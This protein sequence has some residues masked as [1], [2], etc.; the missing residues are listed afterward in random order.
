MNQRK[1]CFIDRDGTIIQEPADEQVDSIDKLDLL[2][3]V[4]PALIQLQLAGFVLVMV[5]NQDGLGSDSFPSEQFWPV[6]Q[7]LERLLLSQGIVFDSVRI[8]PHM[9]SDKCTCRKPNVGL[10]LDYLTSQQIDRQNSY[11]IGDRASDSQ[12]ADNMGINSILIDGK[13]DWQ[14]IFERIVNKPRVACVKRKTNETNITGSLNLK[15]SKPSQIATGI[16]FYDHMLEQIAKH[17][18][19]ELQLTVQGDLQ[20]DDH[21]TVEDSALVLGELFKLA[22]GDKCGIA[23][24][25][26]VLPM[27]ES[28]AQVAID[29][30]GRAYCTFNGVFNR[31]SIGG[32]STE[33]I[34]HF[35]RSFS[36]SLGATIN[37]YV[38]GENTHHMIE[39]CFKGLGRSL[40]QAITKIE[41]GLPTTKGVL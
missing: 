12:L 34:G 32:L 14:N 20:I 30:S 5:T 22:L 31:E 17:A 26:F 21:H 38:T 27:D 18:G 8:C 9:T 10:V 36:D 16:G 15:S 6:Q 13:T 1:Y 11:V 2:P 33:L 7:L 24:Y 23:R 29:L 35:F 39:A 25:G 37:V 19:V 40:R 28:L 41:V 3:G 4:I